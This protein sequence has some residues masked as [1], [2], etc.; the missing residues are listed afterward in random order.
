MSMSTTTCASGFSPY[1]I[2]IAH[3]N[4]NRTPSA[5]N[6]NVNLSTTEISN[7]PYKI[8]TTGTNQEITVCVKNCSDGAIPSKPQASYIYDANTTDPVPF[9]CS[10][11]SKK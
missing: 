7:Y 5:T 8:N 2:K 3:T 1:K 4:V 10:D 9:I 6:R 11:W